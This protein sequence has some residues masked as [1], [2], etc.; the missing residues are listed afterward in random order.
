MLLKKL[1]LGEAKNGVNP[2]PI[3]WQSTLLPFF[4]FQGRQVWENLTKKGYINVRV[5][6]KNTSST[7]LS[8]KITNCSVLNAGIKYLKMGA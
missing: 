2:S 6:E 8:R 3:N 5:V 1:N 7:F 4:I